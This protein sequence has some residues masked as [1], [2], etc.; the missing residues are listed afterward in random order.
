MSA[1]AYRLAAAALASAV[2]LF[3]AFSSFE[4]AIAV[5][6]VVVVLLAAQTGRRRDIVVAGLGSLS[7]T[8]AAYLVSHGA[9][10]VGSATVR[11]LVSGA[12]IA[13][14]T[15]LALRNQAGT[16][17][18]AAQARLLDLSHDMIFVRDARG[19]IRFWNRA[20]EETYG[21]SS[22]EA[23]G[24]VADEL[25]GTRY[26]EDRAA[27][28]ARV[29]ETGRWEGTLEHT[30]RSGARVVVESRWSVESDAAGQPVRLL[31]TH[32]D[33]TERKAA[34]AA[35]VRSERRFRHMFDTSR[36]G[37]VEEDWSAARA[38]LAAAAAAEGAT[39]A[40]YL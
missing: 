18:L 22:A 3:D 28:D 4:G 15:L 1:A 21:W 12:A 6:Y 25:L 24:R 5:V 8:L 23:V 20:A 7:L 13:T 30:A 32:T 16:E 2:F 11:A 10:P 39:E 27:I 36:V 9:A 33:I 37:I 35:L 29:L 26:P 17:L 19:V 31:E 40:E 38:A 14:A 34:Y